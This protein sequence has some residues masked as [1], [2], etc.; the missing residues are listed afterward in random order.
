M[1]N[2][3]KKPSVIVI[4]GA[5]HIGLPLSLCIAKEGF[6]VSIYDLNKEILKKINDGIFPYKEQ[7]GKY[8]L[9]KILKKKNFSISSH[10][11]E[12]KKKILLLFVLVPLLMNI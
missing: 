6:P 4:G 12:I 9:K 2:I 3:N 8:L 7:G 5:G 1:P 10:I 11:S